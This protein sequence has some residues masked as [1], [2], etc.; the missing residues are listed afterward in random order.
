M[1]KQFLFIMVLTIGAVGFCSAAT[2]PYSTDFSTD[3]G[4]VT[5]QPSNLHWDADSGSYFVH[6]EY[7]GYMPS[8]YSYK[9][10]DEPVSSFELRWDVNVTRADGGACALQFGIYD[11]H[12]GNFPAGAEYI[13]LHAGSNGGL[14]WWNM[15]VS[16][17]G[18]NVD[19]SKPVGP[20]GEN[21]WDFNEWYSCK[22]VYDSDLLNVSIQIK[23]RD[24][25]QEIWTS[26]L[27]VPNS[28]FSNELKYLGTAGNMPPCGGSIT[29]GYI[30]NVNLTPEPATLFLLGL[31]SLALLRKRRK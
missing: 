15:S 20:V 17:G 1:R 28:G 3:P 14:R 7:P 27:S 16:A 12:L 30:D 24:D 2:I 23:T 31:G 18:T 29:E 10:L 22:I 6:S 19:T 4:W 13:W 25:Q 26:N 9:L 5:D 21:A 8:R 11:S